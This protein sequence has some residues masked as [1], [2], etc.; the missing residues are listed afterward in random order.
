MKYIMAAGILLVFL[1]GCTQKKDSSADLVNHFKQMEKIFERNKNDT[2]KLSEELAGYSENNME[3]MQKGIQ[4]LYGKLENA[5][6]NP[7]ASFD[8]LAKVTEISAIIVTIQNEY[9]T[10]LK[11]PQVQ[12][13]F[14]EYEKVFSSMESFGREK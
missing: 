14:K 6:E 3:S 7:L 9:G 13:S 1:C 2:A 5:K 10:L 8:L 12:K 11:D 4:A